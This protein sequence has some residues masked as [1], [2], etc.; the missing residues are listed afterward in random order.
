MYLKHL[1]S[2]KSNQGKAHRID[3]KMGYYSCYA[4]CQLENE[5]SP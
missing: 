5:I 2:L 1:Q 4:L 3:E